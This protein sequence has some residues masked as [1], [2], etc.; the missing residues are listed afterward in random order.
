LKYIFNLEFEFTLD[1]FKEFLKTSSV[2]SSKKAIFLAYL[3][4]LQERVYGHEE[5]TNDVIERLISHFKGILKS[6]RHLISKADLVHQEEEIINKINLFPWRRKFLN[7]KLR[8]EIQSH[9]YKH[10][11]YLRDALEEKDEIQAAEEYEMARVLV[12]LLPHKHRKRFAQKLYDYKAKIEGLMRETLADEDA[13]D[14]KSDKKE[15]NEAKQ[16]K[17][18]SNKK[19]KDKKQSK[20]EEN[21]S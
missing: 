7:K 21:K 6:S 19:K 10:L 17:K 13:E 4:T 12:Y 20:K 5:I 16:S 18:K 1:E 11:S 8:M 9:I 2:S 14:K 3:K 15:S